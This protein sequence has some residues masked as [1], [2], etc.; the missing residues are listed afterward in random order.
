MLNYSPS[1][2]ELEDDW[3]T[4]H[5]VTD[6]LVEVMGKRPLLS[7]DESKLKTAFAHAAGINPDMIAVRAMA[8]GV[9]E[10]FIVID[11]SSRQAVARLNHFY[12]RHRDLVEE[13][14]SICRFDD[15]PH[16]RQAYWQELMGQSSMTHNSGR[17]KATAR[18]NPSIAEQ[19]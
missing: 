9:Q 15:L 14:V 12:L 19:Y 2:T 18:L 1:A 11:L 17:L 7:V 3:L 16:D 4:D 6:T 8:A 13:S 5:W 10:L